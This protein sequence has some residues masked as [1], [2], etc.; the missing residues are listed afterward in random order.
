MITTKLSTE[1]VLRFS[2]HIAPEPRR[3]TRK[4]FPANDHDLTSAQ[5]SSRHG[6]FHLARPKVTGPHPHLHSLD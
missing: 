2:A 3:S 6:L 5:T 1:Q 4:Q